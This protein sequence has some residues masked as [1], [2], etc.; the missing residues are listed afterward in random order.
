MRIHPLWGW[1]ALTVRTYAHTALR[2]SKLGAGRIWTI[3]H[4]TLADNG[5]KTSQMSSKTRNHSG[6]QFCS[7]TIF[8]IQFF[9]GSLTLSIEYT[10][11]EYSEGVLAAVDCMRL[12]FLPELWIQARLG[13]DLFQFNE[14]TSFLPL[15]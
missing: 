9:K 11:H 12:E 13:K 6:L 10:H 4:G 8:S 14:K 5:T 15:G 2:I 7:T 1:F 3:G